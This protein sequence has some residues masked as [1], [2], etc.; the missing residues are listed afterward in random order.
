MSPAIKHPHLVLFIA[1]WCV[2]DLLIPLLIRASHRLGILDRPGG[3]KGQRVPV[4]FLGGVG[5]FAAFT[6]GVCATP[7]LVDIDDV[8]PFLAVLLCGAVVL[9]LGLLDDLRP[10]NAVYKLTV[11]FV[12]TLV[13]ASCGITLELFPKIAWNLPNIAITL[14][15]IVGVT[16]A[17]NSLDNTDG[18]VGGVSA[19][20]AA[21]ILAIAW[22]TSPGNAQPW[23]S[24][25]A[26]ALLGACLGFLRYN[27]HPARIYLGDNGAFFVGYCLATLLVFAHY[28]KDPLQ[29]VL[30]PALI[31]AVPIFDL[32]LATAL[33]IRDGQVR[34][35]RAAILYCGRDHLAHLFMAMGMSKVQTAL[36]IYAL[37]IAGGVAGLLVLAS[38][39]PGIYLSIA[40]L[41]GTLLVAVG[42]T[43]GRFRRRLDAAARPELASGEPSAESAAADEARFLEKSAAPDRARVAQD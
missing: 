41:Y 31:L 24:Y 16:S 2:A 21:F 35:V 10:I 4:P 37:A 36:A 30:V 3:H 25:L 43:A 17:M 40:G 26:V 38:P 27:F 13:L 8:Y 20:A 28:S 22:G 6:V 23:L 5:I 9:T 1:A 15:W 19:I 18:V 32:L 29:A 11:L 33:R 42:A 7:F 12:A 34:T 39:R 14:L